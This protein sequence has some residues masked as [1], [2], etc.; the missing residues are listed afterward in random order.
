MGTVS[1]QLSYPLDLVAL[2]PKNGAPLHRQLCDQ[3]RELI[4]EGAVPAGTR[5]PSIRAFAG[6]LAISRVD[7]NNISSNGSVV[8]EPETGTIHAC[9]GPAHAAEWIDLRR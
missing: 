5:L 8:M 1:N 6:E 4:L 3:L 7:F 2:R 9:H